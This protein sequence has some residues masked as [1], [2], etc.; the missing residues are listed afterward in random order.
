M[1]PSHPAR[2]SRRPRPVI[3]LL[4][5]IWPSVFS[6]TLA[7][8]KAHY[9]RERQRKRKCRSCGESYM[10]DAHHFRDQDFCSR[11]ECRKASKQDSQRRW[12]YSPKGAV[13]RDPEYN[14]QRVRE[15]RGAHPD[16]ARLTGGRPRRASPPIGTLKPFDG[17]ALAVSIA[18]GALQDSI[19]SQ[20]V[21]VAVLIA[22]LAGKALQ[23]M[24]VTPP[25]ILYVRGQHI[26]GMNPGG[27][28]EGNHRDDGYRDNRRTGGAE[29]A[30]HP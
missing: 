4:F 8:M 26:P 27:R 3:R 14:R 10:P 24:I 5:V 18:G 13:Y 20:P 12:Y 29:H 19:L 6:W 7:A 9:P 21:V 22:M 17:K 15:W 1:N 2:S 16:Y 23:E 30:R 11:P 25:G 28:P